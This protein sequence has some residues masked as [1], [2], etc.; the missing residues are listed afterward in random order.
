MQR[1]VA[2]PV[3]AS[4]LSTGADAPPE[5]PVSGVFKHP[6]DDPTGDPLLA[7]QT[8][9][10]MAV[11]TAVEG[12]HYRNPGAFM[13]FGADGRATGQLTSGCIERDLALHAVGVAATGR[14]KSLRYGVGSPYIDLQLPCGGGLE[15]SL[16]PAD[17]T[18]IS[19]LLARRRD[20]VA[21]RLGL[22]LD[23]G[24]MAL[25]AAGFSL[26]VLPVTAFSIWG[27]G[28]EAVTFAALAHAA[29]YPVRLH[30]HDEVTLASARAHGIPTHGPAWNG[31]DRWTAVVLFYHD[32]DREPAVLQQALRSQAFYIGAQG[33]LRT[34]EARKRALAQL[35][36]SA[37]E[38]ARL[39]GPIG[40]IRS[41]R[42]PKVLAVSVLAE[43][44]SETDHD[45][46]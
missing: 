5:V 8:G 11:I 24:T 13:A 14:P 31:A 46:P 6:L 30:S 38:I 36:L 29:G 4:T 33:S 21:S 7:L 16:L 25:D 23:R 1:L 39:R 2:S 12:P 41:A 26:P 34:H 10:V 9:G 37:A 27:A 18:V 40:L 28:I 22:D 3:P 43:I 35:G 44:L 19:D 32:H 20:R 45:D 17:P 42:D 15:V